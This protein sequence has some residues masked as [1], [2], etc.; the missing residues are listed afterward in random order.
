MVQILDSVF[1]VPGL[2]LGSIVPV[3]LMFSTSH[4]GPPLL[5]FFLFV[6]QSIV[7]SHPCKQDETGDDEEDPAALIRVLVVMIDVFELPCEDK[8]SHS[9]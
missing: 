8:K 6:Q 5:L 2:L 4:P 9:F 7:E 3:G 1:C